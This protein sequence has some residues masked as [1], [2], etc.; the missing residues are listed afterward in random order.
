MNRP[1]LLGAAA[2]VSLA[3]LTSCMPEQSV[4]AAVKD[5][6]TRKAAP[7]FTLKDANGKTVKLTDYKGKV[8]LLNF[9]ATW[10]GPCKIEIPWFKEFETTYKNQGFAVLGVAMDDDG[11]DAVKPYL[12]DKE[13]N[14][15]VVVGTEQVSLLYG[16]VESLPTTFVIDREG[17][18]ASVH[19]GLISK[20]DYTNEIKQLLSPDKPAEKPATPTAAGTNAGY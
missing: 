16:D 9:W 14:Y 15:R 11:W 10:C 12:A 1:Q 2:I 4:R 13:V 5:S 7:D 6:K 18:I 19:V 3:V 8:V 20:G 17:R